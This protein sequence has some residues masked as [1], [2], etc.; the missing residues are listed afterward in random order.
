MSISNFPQEAKKFEIQAFK[1]P[2]DLNE[3]K[4]SHVAFT[5][6]PVKHPHDMNKVVLV[7]DPYSGSTFYYE[8]TTG[9]ISYLEE[10]PSIVNMD[11]ETVPMARLW[12]KKTSLGVRCIPFLV[13]N[14]KQG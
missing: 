2:S 11:G 3:L 7:P 6:S 14:L 1:Q 4:K 10:L 9:D 12:V 13:E 5:G 8:F